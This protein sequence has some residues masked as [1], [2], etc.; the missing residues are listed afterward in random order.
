MVYMSKV[1][2][3]LSDQWSPRGNL[4]FLKCPPEAAESAWYGAGINMATAWFQSLGSAYLAIHDH[5]HE[6]ECFCNT[7]LYFIVTLRN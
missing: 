4:Q 2:S 6:G 3:S 5:S 1:S 7:L